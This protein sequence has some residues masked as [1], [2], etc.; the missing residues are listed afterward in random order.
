MDDIRRYFRHGTLVQLRVFEAVVRLGSFTRAAEELFMAQPTVSVHMKKLAETVGVPLV[1]LNGKKVELTPA[2]ECVYAACGDIFETFRQLE[3][4]LNGGASGMAAG[5]SSA[6]RGRAPPPSRR[7]A[8]YRS[9]C[10]HG[11]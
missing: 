9:A 6:V 7:A 5:V 1:Q 4:A 10:R 8:G 2:G 3:T 11:Q